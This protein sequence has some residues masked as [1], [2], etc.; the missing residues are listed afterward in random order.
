MRGRAPRP[1]Y[2]TRTSFM[3]EIKAF[4]VASRHV[5]ALRSCHENEDQ[6]GRESVTLSSLEVREVEKGRGLGIGDLALG[7]R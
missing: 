5:L 2:R 3:H 1:P 6:H 4:H 7:G